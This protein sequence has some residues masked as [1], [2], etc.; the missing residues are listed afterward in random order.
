MNSVLLKQ[1]FDLIENNS[2]IALE[3]PLPERLRLLTSIAKKCSAEAISCYLWSLED[4]QMRQLQFVGGELILQPVREYQPIATKSRCEHYF[5]IL[6]FWK[7]TYLEGVLILEGIFPWLGADTSNPDFFLTSEW[8]KSA[9]INLKIGVADHQ[10]EFSQIWEFQA[11]THQR[12]KLYDGNSKKTAILLGPNASLSS[13]IAAEVPTITQELPTVDQ[14]TAYLPEILHISYNEAELNNIAN[15]SVGMYLADIEYGIRSLNKIASAEQLTKQLSAYKINLLKRVY[16]V[17]FLQPPAIEVGG[18]ELMQESFK[19]YKRLITPLAKAYNL[20]LPKGVL[21]IGPPGTGKSHSAKAC[22]QRLGVPLIVVEW[23]NFRSYGNLAEYK[24]KKLLALVDRI[25]RIIFYLDDF[26]KGF[27][28]DDDLSRRLAGMLLTWMQERT[29]DV[30]IIASANNLEL[31]PPELTRCGRFD[32][33]FKVDLPNNGERHQIFKIHLRRF[34]KRFRVGNPFT[35]E[36]WRRLLKE[37]QRCVGAEIQTIVEKAAASTFCHMF[38]EDVPLHKLP[39]LEI[40]LTSLLEARQN[41]NPLAIRE[42]DKVETMRNRGDLQGLPSSPVDS[43]IYS[44]GNVN[45]FS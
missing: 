29:S 2:L 17:E 19:K 27:A 10:Y 11:S 26:D 5:E 22:S 39:P 3:S 4:D 23:G 24:L 40:T 15:L 9:L 25:D 35:D 33:I 14:I 20:R 21:L 36:E 7:T 44:V 1:L 8:I 28:G 38:P 30:L 12:L 16:S 18:L 31:L 37:T 34:D 41:I 45:I 43:S 6:R 42:A 32:D 13:D